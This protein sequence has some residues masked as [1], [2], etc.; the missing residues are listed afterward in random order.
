MSTEPEHLFVYGTL[1]GMEDTRVEFVRDDTVRGKLYDLGPFPGFNF[2]VTGKVKG[3]VYKILDR[4]IMPEL[5]QYEGYRADDLKNSLYR[6]EAWV[7]SA[8]ANQLPI[9]IYVYNQPL[10]SK[11]SASLIESGDWTDR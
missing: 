10:S 11:K 5:D 8:L 6:R 3:K 1:M 4:T 9:W 2:A 7:T